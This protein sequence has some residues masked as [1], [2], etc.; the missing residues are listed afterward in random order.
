MKT[1]TIHTLRDLKSRG[2]K[3]PVITA[4]DASFSRLIE[5][6][7]IE[8]VLVGDSLGNVIQG[9]DSTVPVTMDDMAYHVSAVRRGNSKSLIIADLPFMAY[10]S[11]EQA[12]MNAA[13]LM[14]AGAHMVKL[15]GGAW[16]EH[17]VCLLAER[18]IP[19][20]G[21]LGLTPQSVNKLGGYKVQGRDEQAAEM[22]LKDAKLLEQSGIDLL[23]LECVPAALAKQISEELSVPVI[24]IGA[25]A[26]TD[27]Q[28]LVIYDMLGLSPKVPKFSRNFLAETGSLEGALN[29]YAAAVRD[30]SFPGP[31]HGF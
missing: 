31:E 26:D 6:V 1:V 23:V 21:H 17:T 5:Q 13:E 28:V 16:L 10:A 9:Q 15:E 22:M 20:C 11:E 2:E 12:M 18:G 19:V 29:A 4:Y 24:G 25:G 7:G 3:F 8:V 27:A 14:Q 30:G